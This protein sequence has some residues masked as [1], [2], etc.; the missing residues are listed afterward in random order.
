[1]LPDRP[2]QERLGRLLHLVAL[3]G[4]LERLALGDLARLFRPSHPAVLVALEI[5]LLPSHLVV[6]AGLSHRHPVVLEGLFLP[7]HLAVPAALESLARRHP[8]VLEGLFL[9]SHLAVP[10]AP[11]SLARC[12]LRSWRARFSLRTLRSLRSRQV[13]ARRYRLAAQAGLARLWIPRSRR[14]CGKREGGEKSNHG[15]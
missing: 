7:S 2:R 6:R 13:L 3:E 14:T 11:E 1:M 15:D 5:L 9:P 8:V 4:L 12:A 10:V